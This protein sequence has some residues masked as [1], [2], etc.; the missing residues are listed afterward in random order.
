MIVTLSKSTK[1]NEKELV[2]IDLPPKISLKLLTIKSLNYFLSAAIFIAAMAATK[3][4]FAPHMADF[5]TGS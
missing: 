5:M 2:T 4:N 1:F 3:G